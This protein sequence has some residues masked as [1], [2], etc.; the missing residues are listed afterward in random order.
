[1]SGAYKRG[2]VLCKSLAFLLYLIFFSISTALSAAPTDRNCEVV[3]LLDAS[4]SM[5]TTDPEGLAMDCIEQMICSLPSNYAAGFISY[6]SQLKV[7]KAL[8][9]DRGGLKEAVRSVNYTGYTNAGAGLEKALQL[10]SKDAAMGKAVV[11]LS[12][13]EINLPDEGATKQSLE[14]F[15]RARQEAANRG[16][17]IYTIAIGDKRSAP[18]SNIYGADGAQGQEKIYETATPTKLADIA[19]TIVY[20]DFGVQKNSVSTGEIQSG[21]LKV[22]IPIAH[23]AYVSRAKI[24]VTA[25]R[26]LEN[27]SASYNAENGEINIGK[28]FALV[29][30]THPQ[31]NE[32]ELQLGSSNGNSIRADLILEIKAA[33]EAEAT[34]PDGSAGDTQ[35]FVDIHLTPIGTEDESQH[36][37]DDPYFEGKSVR[38][39]ADG[40]EILAKVNKGKI[41]FS[42]SAETTRS[43]EI[44]VHFEDLGVNVIAPERIFVQ[45]NRP[46]G[47]G[48]YLMM[49]ISAII[50][51]GLL[52]WYKY[53]RPKL[54][55]LP[56]LAVSRYD[57]AGKL[58]I[59]ISKSP[60]D[61]DI[62]PQIYNL[63]R[64]FSKEEINL[65]TILEQCNI[66]LDFQGAYKIWFSPGASKALVITNKSDCTILKS[67]DLLIKDHS[68]LLYFD[69][70]LHITFEDESSEVILYYKTIKPGDK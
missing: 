46:E 25:D 69:E 47:Y 61:S 34:R 58:Q 2:S 63:S 30:I 59:Y 11:L 12:D 37:L 45:V 67:R 17:R 54:P 4:N 38:V 55:T 48:K 39:T 16:I 56:P 7:V 50:A 36:F 60:D 5:N 65:G 33:I 6:D 35:K 40:E 42:L 31:I 23:T 66:K 20:E 57:Y 29:D 43:V 52:L 14:R 64:R 22:Q 41:N 70:R 13:G 3:F 19:K 26:P 32:M 27:V 53:R 51:I 18:P 44:K 1:M 68:C 28:R 9:D 10:F 24:L 21:S 49:I 62:A 15:N 8:S